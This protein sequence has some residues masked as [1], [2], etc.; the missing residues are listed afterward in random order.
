MIQ[1]NRLNDAIMFNKVK[2]MTFTKETGEEDFLNELVDKLVNVIHSTIQKNKSK[3]IINDDFSEM[4]FDTIDE[5]KSKFGVS[6]MELPSHCHIIFGNVASKI[7]GKLK[8]ELLSAKSLDKKT[9]EDIVK[10]VVCSNDN[11]YSRTIASYYLH[12]A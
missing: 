9:I 4:M 10:L 11:I 7:V 2:Y 8:K 12:I 5:S 1:S 6:V 3:L